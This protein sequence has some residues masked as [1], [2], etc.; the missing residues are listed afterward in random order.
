MF[1]IDIA[2]F[3]TA[4]P[5]SS[6]F[7]QRCRQPGH[8]GDDEKDVLNLRKNGCGSVALISKKEED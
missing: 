2:I 6:N 4:L 1:A 7:E 5:L 3:F 8:I